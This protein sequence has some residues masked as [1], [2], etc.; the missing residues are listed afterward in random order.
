L[1]TSNSMRGVLDEL[2]PELE[3]TG[4]ARIAASFDPAQIMLQRIA[5]GETADL[6]ILGQAAIDELSRQGKLVH[7]SQRTLARCGVGIGVRAG[8]PK[9]DVSTVEALKRA[10]LDAKSVAY[11]S[12]GASGIH[13]AGIIEQLGI[14]IEVKAKAVNQPG[15]LIGERIVSG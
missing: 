6:T 2:I 1:L 11:T 5:G 10:L 12:S 9:P 7:G 13:F 15:G 14:A 8:A 4:G 3:R